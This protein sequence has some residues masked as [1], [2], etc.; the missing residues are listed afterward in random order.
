MTK[1]YATYEV[2]FVLSAI[3]PDTIVAAVAAKTVWNMI[4]ASIGILR[5]NSS[6]VIFPKNPEVPIIPPKSLPTPQNHRSHSAIN[7]LGWGGGW[8]QHIGTGQ[9]N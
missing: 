5:P 7:P 2:N 4:N 6:E 3:A 9:I 8:R 1:L